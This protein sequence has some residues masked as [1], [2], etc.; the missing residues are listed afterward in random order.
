MRKQSDNG[1]EFYEHRRIAKAL[2]IE[3]MQTIT[4]LDEEELQEILR[5][6]TG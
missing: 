2:S 5:S 4:G 1:T 6:T 3:Q